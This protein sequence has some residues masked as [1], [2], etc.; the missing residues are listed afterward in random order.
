MRLLLRL[1]TMAG[2]VF[3][4]A[5]SAADAV[6]P[7]SP[8]TTAVRPSVA[9]AIAGAGQGPLPALHLGLARRRREYR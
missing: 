4:L 5:A 7:L 8:T 3:A 6:D 1:I 9:D 2:I